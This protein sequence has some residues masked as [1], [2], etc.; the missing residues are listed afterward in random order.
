MRKSLLTIII[1]LVSLPALAVTQKENDSC[2]I[3][4]QF[5]NDVMIIRQLDTRL[6]EAKQI[7]QSTYKPSMSK[8]AETTLNSIIDASY[9]VELRDTPEDKKEIVKDF[10]KSIYL[11]CLGLI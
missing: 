4:Q 3:Y 11:K 9:V 6:A 10:S 7:M 5:A 2:E 1:T 8:D